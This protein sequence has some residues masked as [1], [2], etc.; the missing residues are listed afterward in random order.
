MAK[1]TTE[2]SITPLTGKAL[3]KKVKELS[4]SSRKDTA[5]ACGYYSTTKDEQKRVNLT[6]FYDAVLKAK[7]IPLDDNGVKDGRGR[8]ATYRACVH[9][10]GQL[11]IGANYTQEMGLK[12][13]DE[14]VIQLGHKH[15][16]LRQITELEKED[17]NNDEEE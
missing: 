5:I 6:K 3:L 10:N 15:I 4:S 17:E 8:A 14:F 13:G 11:V 1:T 16:H 2:K 9:K 7:G 12:P